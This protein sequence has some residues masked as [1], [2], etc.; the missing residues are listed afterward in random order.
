MVAENVHKKRK[1]T[2]GAKISKKR[3]FQECTLIPI[4]VQGCT[5]KLTLFVSK[6]VDEL[7]MLSLSFIFNL[8]IIF[9][10]SRSEDI[11]LEVI[12]QYTYILSPNR[13]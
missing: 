9:F 4:Y 10:S 8:S 7:P 12:S 1:I 5:Y 2:D 6:K 11:S 13:R 3:K